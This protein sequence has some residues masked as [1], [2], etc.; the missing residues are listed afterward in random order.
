MRRYAKKKKETCAQLPDGLFQS[1]VCFNSARHRER[2]DRKRWKVK[3]R[4]GVKYERV[5]TTSRFCYVLQLFFI[6][7]TWQFCALGYNME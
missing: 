5:G 2:A 4:R 3:K 6:S 7:S 1:L